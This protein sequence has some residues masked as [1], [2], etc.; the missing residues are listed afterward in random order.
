[1]YTCFVLLYLLSTHLRIYILFFIL[2]GVSRYNYSMFHLELSF[3]PY[4]L[5]MKYN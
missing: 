2:L 1:M 3:I 4:S 5:P